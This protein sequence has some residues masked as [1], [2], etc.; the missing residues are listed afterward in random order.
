MFDSTTEVGLIYGRKPASKQEWFTA[1]GL[2][3]IGWPFRYQIPI[4]GGRLPGGQILDFL[5][6]TQP[7]GT[8]L[9]VFSNYY[10]SAEITSED[11]FKL[12]VIAEEFGAFPV[13]FWSIDL[14]T[15]EMAIDLVLRTF[16]RPL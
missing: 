2:W 11:T 13:V 14:Q 4:R 1:V 8:P 15:P 16:G 6:A 5:V 7:R 12:Q 10:H 9:Q 3:Q